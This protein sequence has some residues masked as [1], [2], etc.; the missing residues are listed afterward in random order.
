MKEV[1]PEQRDHLQRLWGICTLA[2]HN[3]KPAPIAVSTTLFVAADSPFETGPTR[4]P[5]DDLLGWKT[6][7]HADLERHAVPG[8]HFQ[9]FSPERIDLVA[10]VISSTIRGKTWSRTIERAVPS[11]HVDTST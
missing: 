4:I 7:I 3:Y 5:I 10:R 2:L 6:W 9:I 8:N 1:D 11:N